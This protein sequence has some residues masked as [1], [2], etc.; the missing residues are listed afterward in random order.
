MSPAAKIKL[1]NADVAL[2]AHSPIAENRWGRGRLCVRPW[3]RKLLSI[4]FFK[5]EWGVCVKQRSLN[6]PVTAF[7]RFSMQLR[8]LVIHATR[9]HSYSDSGYYSDLCTA[10]VT[11]S[12]VVFS[13]TIWFSW[14]YVKQGKFFSWGFKSV[15]I[16]V[17]EN[18]KCFSSFLSHCCSFFPTWSE[19]QKQINTE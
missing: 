9:K 7:S 5:S 16:C 6:R 13:L 10:S 18:K 12:D 2:H 4:Y 11:S 17:L 8:E 15:I 3:D 1:L 14:L 19:A